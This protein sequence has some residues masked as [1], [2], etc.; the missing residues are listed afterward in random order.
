MRVEHA[1]AGV[2]ISRIAKD[3][4]ELGL[5]S[6]AAYEEANAAVSSA[7]ADLAATQY[8]IA[9]AVADLGRLTGSL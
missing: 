7:D 1:V 4:F 9:A 6:R 5:C 3:Q 8:Q 2:K